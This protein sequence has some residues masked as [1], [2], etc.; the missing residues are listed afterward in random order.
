M[1]PHIFISTQ[2]SGLSQ[3]VSERINRIIDLRVNVGVKDT[4]DMQRCL[5]KKIK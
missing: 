1:S 4:C 2:G 3:P 5:R